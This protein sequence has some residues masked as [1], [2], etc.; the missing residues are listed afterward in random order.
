LKKKY[1]SFY[2]NRYKLHGFSLKSNLA[3]T[4][5]TLNHFILSWTL[6]F[7][8]IFASLAGQAQSTTKSPNNNDYTVYLMAKDVKTNV[9][10]HPKFTVVTQKGGNVMPIKESDGK[11]STQLKLHEVYKISVILDG[12][13]TQERTLKIPEHP[14]EK[15]LNV[16]FSLN[17]KPTATLIVHTLDEQSNENI[18]ASFKISHQG[19]EFLGKTSK[20]S[21]IFNITFAE[22]GEYTI[23]IFSPLHLP[24]KEPFGLE[25][26][27]PSKIYNKEIKLQKPNNGI[28]F[29]IIDNEKEQRI[30][31]VQLKIINQ[32]DNQTIFDEALPNGDAL[33]ALNPAKNYQLSISH[34]GFVT[35]KYDIRAS[36]QKEYLIKLP[37][38]SF[39]SIG[40]FD[41][42]SKKRIPA[43]IQISFE[44]N[45][46]E[47]LQGNTENDLI[48]RSVK[49]G[50]YS[51]EASAPNYESKK[52]TINLVN[53]SEGK[54]QVKLLM[55]STFENCII[56][57][58]DAVS[59]QL[60]P[61]PSVKIYDNEKKL[62]ET[63]LNPKTGEYKLQLE[64]NKEYFTDIQAEGYSKQIGTLTRGSRLITI[65]M[66]KAIQ[67]INYQVLDALTLKPIDAKFTIIRPNESIVAGFSNPNK[68]FQ[69][70]IN[71]NESYRL[72][73]SS[74]GYNA[75]IEEPKYINNTEKER[76]IEIK[77]SKSNYQVQFKFIDSKNKNNII[78]NRYTIINQETKKPVTFQPNELG[79]KLN[80]SPEIV[81]EIYIEAEGYQ[82]LTQTLNSK[83]FIKSGNI[84][85][86]IEMNKKVNQ[87]YEIV[88]VD[89][90]NTALG[91]V[92]IKITSN[93]GDTQIQKNP[94]GNSWFVSLKENEKYRII[95][96]KKG[97]L[98]YDGN[99]NFSPN[100]TKI[101]IRLSEIPAQTF[102][103]QC[104]DKYSH[105]PIQPLIT[106]NNK[107]KSEEKQIIQANQTDIKY[108]PDENYVVSIKLDGYED[109]IVDF[110]SNQLKN[111]IL[112]L[113]LVKK[114][115]QY[116]IQVF[117]DKSKE[118]IQKANISIKNNLN[119]SFF[120]R[121]NTKNNQFEAELNPEGQ[122]Q[123]E[124]LADNYEK[125]IE[126]FSGLSI[127]EKANFHLDTWLKAKV[128]AEIS[129]T[130]TQ[131]IITQPV[132]QTE[133]AKPIKTDTSIAKPIK[134]T[135]VISEAITTKI[136]E[137]VNPIPTKI[138]EI[139]KEADPIVLNSQ[140]FSQQI[141]QIITKQQNFQLSNI[142]F[143]QSSAKISNQAYPQLDQLVRI[144]KENP[145]LM[146]QIEGFTDNFGDL[147][148]NQN[149]SYFRAKVVSNYLFNKGIADS[150]MQIKGSGHQKPLAPNTNEENRIKNRRVEF[151]FQLLD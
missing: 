49:K 131:A 90:Q 66:N 84:E 83:E 30:K 95:A 34:P 141:S 65:Q 8:F 73:I 62:V 81:Y 10:L 26:G 143:E 138:I 139:E 24:Y 36:S 79:F 142:N 75:V 80:L 150:R 148:V 54:I 31:N 108:N 118:K 145:K 22:S 74:E 105:T 5:N 6:L 100:E 42:Y 47:T 27:E 57:I 1:N 121:Y 94:N 114:V 151:T 149:L 119:Q 13:H 89:K 68:P 129:K 82:S 146:L 4:M 37:L 12:Y 78:P 104:L 20:N 64:K 63:Q 137:K 135:P 52:E 23:E 97:F 44:G 19:K 147:R 55:E 7:L 69:V 127:A 106:F 112:T 91:E 50:L 111:Q 32:N 134:P 110:N 70:N 11:F 87:K 45:S 96:E 115:Y 60:I 28:K 67:K 136:E 2:K 92:N 21:P 103:I 18:E 122:Y 117:D 15:D 88:L 116:T 126:S 51:I 102:K 109:K 56:L 98:S 61:N 107:T 58:M 41:Q 120:A 9:Q 33:V 17:P 76:K 124:I 29:T 128:K 132:V 123:I 40:T 3:Y 93:E 59:K 99:L 16:I 38:E 43:N 144:M 71:P 125:H 35:L 72:E 140:D 85:Q 25:T 14:F 130:E 48:Y 39:F 113:D 53:L 77:L 46:P 133:K 101:S 86:I